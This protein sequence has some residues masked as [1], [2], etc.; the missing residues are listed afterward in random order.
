MSKLCPTCH[1]EHPDALEF[2]PNDGA[3]LLASPAAD[4]AQRHKPTMHGVTGMVA[5]DDA[6]EADKSQVDP[7]LAYDAKQVA[8]HMAALRAQAAAPAAPP[9]AAPVASRSGSGIT[10]RAL[11]ARGSMAADQAVARIAQ[12]AEVRA[13]HPNAPA[14]LTPDHVFYATEDGSGAPRI[15][16][17]PASA[18]DPLY[19]ATY[20]APGVGVA[21]AADVYAL[22]CMLFECL[23]GKPPFRGRSVEEIGRR[24]ATAAAPAVRQVRT[25]CELPPTLELELQ[26]ALKKRPGDRHPTLTAFA[27]A[28]RGAMREDD[29]ATMA[30]GAGEAAFLQQLLA[31]RADAPAAAGAVPPPPPSARPRRVH[32]LTPGPMARV[33]PTPGPMP[34]AFVEPQAP[35][36]APPAGKGKLIA[37]AVAG[38]VALGVLGVAIGMAVHRPA[39]APKQEQAIAAPAPP[40]SVPEPTPEPPQPDV[41]E[42]PTPDIV[43]EPETPDVLVAEDTGEAAHKHK[44]DKPVVKKPTGD[45]GAQPPPPPHPDRPI[46]F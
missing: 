26:H 44:V 7:T 24:H 39:A 13:A 25:D 18:A 46:T 2:C 35:V 16:P 33:R 31:G 41:Q 21:S 10:L 15:T 34:A 3:H 1:S 43:A 45:P 6:A 38:L 36:A 29:R 19:A 42:A 23:T 5:G 27:E 11:L 17:E 22:G 4:S 37:I 32:T 20:A 14:N 40:P 12:L 9:P 30:L 28:I 8:A